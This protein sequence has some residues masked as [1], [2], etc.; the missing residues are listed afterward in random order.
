[1]SDTEELFQQK[2]KLAIDEKKILKDWENPMR[3]PLV[4]KV[5]VN[6]AVGESGEPLQKAKQVLETITNGRT[7]IECRAKDSVR[8]FNVRKGEPIGVR[9]TL[10]G[11]EA[12]DFL[13]KVFWA[14]E[15]FI[16]YKNWD[17]EGNLAMGIKDHLTLP[18]TRY[19]PKLGVQGFGVTA[20][21]ERPG[22]R[23]KRR[24]Y[25]RK[26]VGR[27]HRIAKDEAV[28][29]Y[30]KTFNLKLIEDYPERMM[31]F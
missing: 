17:N 26:K 2:I 29:F 11:Q 12:V 10:R 1:M 3:K 16:S 25:L 6:F 13:K 8:G 22:F 31:S 7:A 9:V 19:D 14:K 30:Q 21:L 15:D 18:D 4:A 23:I 5:V 27:H 28:F 20:V 24:K